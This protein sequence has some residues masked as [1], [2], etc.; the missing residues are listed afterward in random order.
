VGNVKVRTDAIGIKGLNALVKE[1]RAASK[2]APRAVTRANKR[3]AEFI[4]GRARARA[5]ALGG[6]AGHVAPT[7]KA[8]GTAKVSKVTGGGAGRGEPFFGAEFGALR[9]HQFKP[10]RGNQWAPDA[11]N[12]VGY[13]L[14]PVVRESREEFVKIYAD[15]LEEELGG[16]FK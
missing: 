13:F 11:E 10:W 3:A 15:T 14:H 8:G 12:G 9:Y 4:A 1:L 5:A 7:I 2:T 6:V 16:L